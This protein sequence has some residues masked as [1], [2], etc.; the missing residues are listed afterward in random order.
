MSFRHV[1]HDEV[2][3]PEGRQSRGELRQLRGIETSPRS[4]VSYARIRR[5]FTGSTL[6]VEGEWTAS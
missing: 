3:W 4:W 5:I 2:I 1:P 6:T